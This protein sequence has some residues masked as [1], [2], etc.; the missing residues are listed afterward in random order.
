MARPNNHKKLIVILDVDGTLVATARYCCPLDDADRAAADFVI[1]YSSSDNYV[2]QLRADLPEFL[3]WLFE[4]CRVVVWSDN[5]RDHVE[6]LVRNIFG[7]FA[8]QIERIYDE[9]HVIVAHVGYGEMGRV[10]PIDIV[11]KELEGPCVLIDDRDCNIN[12]NPGRALL[13]SSLNFELELP[14]SVDNE[15]QRIMA[16]IKRIA[17]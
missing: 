7:S 12:Y 11:A 8:S 4:N 15:L 5:P 9:R 13:I 16:E 3:A 10:K 1:E 14:R 6:R 17:C 2:Y